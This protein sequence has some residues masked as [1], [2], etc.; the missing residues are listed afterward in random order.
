MLLTSQPQLGGK[1]ST[2]SFRSTFDGH[3]I[4][5]SVRQ[6]LIDFYARYPQMELSAYA[7][8]PVDE[9]FRMSIERNLKPLIHPDDPYRSVSNLLRFVQETFRYQSD[10]K[11]HGYEKNNFCE[12]NFYYPA[13][14]CEDRAILFSYLIKT[15]VGLDVVLVDY[16]DHVAAAVNF[17]RSLNVDGDYY[18]YN[19]SHYVVCDPTC[20]NAKVGQISSKYKTR[21]PQI[22]N[23]V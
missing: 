20:K 1:L 19:D 22:I 13:N 16:S 17:P 14:D 6:S 9:V 8:A 12:E 2:P 5:V 10:A 18:R 23:I 3:S 7:N 4:V 21:K 15:L 11:T